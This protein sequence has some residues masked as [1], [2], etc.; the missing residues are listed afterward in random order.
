MTC[1]NE[2][3][4]MIFHVSLLLMKKNRFPITR[5]YIFFPH[6]QDQIGRKV[7]IINFMLLKSH[8][9]LC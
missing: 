2:V 9:K 3:F 6:W 7:N 8:V 4:T 5:K 1:A